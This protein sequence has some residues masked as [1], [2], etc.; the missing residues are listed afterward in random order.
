MRNNK[1]KSIFISFLFAIALIFSSCEKEVV[2]KKCTVYLNG[3]VYSTQVVSDCSLCSAPQ[4]FTTS[5]K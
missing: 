4:G 1:I 3:A 5:C 2:S